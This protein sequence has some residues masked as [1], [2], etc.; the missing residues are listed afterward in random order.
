MQEDELLTPVKDTDMEIDEDA[1]KFLKYPTAD[2]I[3][4]E[5][6]EEDENEQLQRDIEDDQLKQLKHDEYL[7]QLLSANEDQ[8]RLKKS[9]R[10]RLSTIKEHSFDDNEEMAEGLFQSQEEALKESMRRFNKE[11]ERFEVQS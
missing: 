2:L 7:N 11:K 3:D 5:E 9:L 4:G 10:E 8:L 6:S 1:P